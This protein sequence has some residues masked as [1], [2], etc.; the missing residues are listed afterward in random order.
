MRSRKG[1]VD[2]S[3]SD[4]STIREEKREKTE[5]EEQEVHDFSPH[6]YRSRDSE[7]PL[8]QAKDDIAMTRRKKTT[9]NPCAPSNLERAPQS[10]SS[11]EAYQEYQ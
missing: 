10:L 1:I 9:T 7:K 6:I 3:A 4:V 2:S 8:P 5:G 11:L